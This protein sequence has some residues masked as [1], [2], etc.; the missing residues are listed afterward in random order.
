MTYLFDA[1]SLLSL[2]WPLV[3]C[4][5]IWGILVWALRQR[6]QVSEA[7]N[8]LLSQHRSAE[9]VGRSD[10]NVATPTVDIGQRAHRMGRSS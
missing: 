1:T 4:A 10:T 7:V 2:I 9:V 3:F 6:D 5:A 8:E